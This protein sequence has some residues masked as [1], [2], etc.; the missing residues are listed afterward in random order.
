MNQNFKHCACSSHAPR[1]NNEE[2][3]PAVDAY[4]I[5]KASR[6]VSSSHRVVSG[7]RDVLQNDLRAMYDTIRMESRNG[8]VDAAS[9]ITYF[10]KYRV[11]PLSQYELDFIKS[12][13]FTT[14]RQHEA[15][16]MQEYI[17]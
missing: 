13:N 4:D 6:D 17:L 5:S 11:V 16:T 8:C 2:R 7:A 12:L 3:R 15:R 14:I 9:T 10:A 1:Q